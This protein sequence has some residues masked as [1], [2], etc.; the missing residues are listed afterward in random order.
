VNLLRQLSD[1]IAGVVDKV[2]PAVLHVRTLHAERRQL[3]GG[4]GV[5][6]TPDGYA[7][8]NSHVVHGAA[9]IEAEL[10]DG[11]VVVCD[12]I[13]DDPLSD[14]ALLRLP[15]EGRL[16]HVALGDSNAV[17]VGDVVVAIGCPLGLAR[18]VTLGV[19]SALGR[20]LQSA[21]PGRQIEGVIQ[22]DAMLNPGNS[23]G[24]LVD[25]EGSV[26]GINTAIVAGGQGL[27]FAV[28]ANTASFVTGEILRHGRVRRAWLGV[29][30]FEAMLPAAIARQAGLAEGRG[31]GVRGVEPSSPAAAA[32][33]RPGDVLV[34]LDGRPVRTVA[35]L[36]AM[37]DAARIG[38]A[39]RLV[40]LRAGRR[41]ELAIVP[42]ELPPL[43]LAG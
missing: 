30:A 2:G 19:V 20:T 39:S 22:T 31:V 43:R 17:R 10:A 26:V 24:P 38:Q 40:V 15:A 42:R 5:V 27:C 1:S 33:L 23:G 41:V 34:E 11:R 37:L 16:A 36:H 28:P 13:G 14:L 7:L 4:S 12:L 21:A 6:I 29:A 32:D 3:G 8:T 35:D 18:S 25:A 9:A